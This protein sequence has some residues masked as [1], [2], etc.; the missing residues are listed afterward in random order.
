MQLPA[1]NHPMPASE[2]SDRPKFSVV[3]IYEDC[4]A[5]RRAKHFYDK[6]INEL[7]EEC[8]FTLELWNFQVLAISEIWHSTVQVAGQADFV[9]LSL[10]GKAVL[11]VEITRWI[12]TWSRLGAGS[13]AALIALVDKIAKRGDTA[14]STL[15]CLRKAAYRKG[16]SFYY[17][18]VFAPATN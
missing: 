16:I 7:E 9:I 13:N 5:G 14:A 2:L 11:P 6:L 12:E 3:V 10:C 1:I 15:T 17:H 4:A 18:T 8:D